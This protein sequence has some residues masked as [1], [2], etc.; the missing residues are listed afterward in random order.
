MGWVV[1]AVLFAA[2]WIWAFHR[3]DRHERE[4][5]WVVGLAFVWGMLSM[6]LALFL[7]ERLLPN[8]V[9]HD[10]ELAVRAI[11]M[12]AVVGPVEELSKFA[13]VR[14]PI[15]R[16]AHFNEPMDG[17]VYSV[18]ASAGFALAE[19]LRFMEGE[20]EVIWARGPAA[21]MA[22]VLFA[23]FWGA[24]LGW[25]KPMADRRLAR[26]IVLLGLFWAMLAHGLYDLAY[27]MADR[28]LPPLA[29]RGAMA[30]LMLVSFLA[31]RLQLRRAHHHSP[32]R[33]AEEKSP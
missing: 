11:A 21:T 9:S 19:N 27:F 10:D 25:T 4:P 5:V 28:E 6:F 20:P 18:A 15:Y 13:A 16:L 2:V 7:E 1:I 14:L 31:L 8:G 30:G 12:L 23:A 17:I 32:F 22:H 3:E 24:A 26:R 33:K 29:A